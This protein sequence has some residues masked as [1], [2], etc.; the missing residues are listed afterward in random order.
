VAIARA[1]ANTPPILV[2]DEPTGR[3]DSSTADTI[4]GIFERLAARGH[5]IIMVSHDPS[6]YRRYSR[7]V[8]LADGHLT[9]QP[10]FPVE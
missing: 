7:V 8:W 5:T 6:L 2:A 3:L 10:Q 4:F 9:D 1:L